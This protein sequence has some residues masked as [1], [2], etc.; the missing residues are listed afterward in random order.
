MHP[1]HTLLLRG[2]RRWLDSAPGGRTPIGGQARAVNTNGARY[3]DCGTRLARENPSSRCGSCQAKARPGGAVT[4][5]ASRLLGHRSHAGRHGDLAYGRVVAAYRNHPFHGRPLPQETVAGWV[6][7]TQ[8]QLSRI[9]SGPP[10]KDLERLIEW[11][12]VLHV[13]PPPAVIQAPRAPARPSAGGAGST[14]VRGWSRRELSA[15][16][17][18]SGVGARPSDR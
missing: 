16:Q 14:P 11:A 7:I 13:P 9:E 2:P 4:R 15:R 3:C 17:Q 18:V 12:R 10:I 1:A 6:G 5:G 8:A